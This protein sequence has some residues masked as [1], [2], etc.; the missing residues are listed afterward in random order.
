MFEPLHVESGLRCGCTCPGCGAPLVAR[1][2]P[3]GK[4]VSN[5]A[6]YRGSSCAL[7]FETAVHLAAK[8]LIADRMALYLPAVR[9]HA[10]GV[11]DDGDLFAQP[12]LFVS[13]GVSRLQ[14]VRV[15]ARVGEIRPD[16][17]VSH[18]GRDVLVEIAVTHFVDALKLCHIKGLGLAAVEIDV[19][20][21]REMNFAALEAALFTSEQKSQWLCHPECD[22]EQA[23]LEALVVDEK[24]RRRAEFDRRREEEVARLEAALQHERV[25]L[26]AFRAAPDAAKLRQALEHLGA[27]DADELGFLPVPVKA[28]NAI[29][30]PP[31][32][33]QVAVFSYLLHWAVSVQAVSISSRRVRAWIEERF[34][35]SGNEQAFAGAVWDFL[36]GLAVLGLLHHEGR[37]QFLITFAGSAGARAVVT[38]ARESGALPLSWARSWPE[39]STT[40]C[41]AMV[42]GSAYGSAQKWERVAGLLPKIRGEEPPDAVIQHYAEGGLD[43]GLL[44]RFFLAVGFAR[45][46]GT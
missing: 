18:G 14:A 4:V 19:S 31:L 27:R 6:H 8:Q 33:W 30:A 22:A 3:E 16:L 26:A 36:N 23:R 40:K 37:Q 12:I 11:A 7:G 17:V 32:V 34:P 25:R 13:A 38:D 44:R 2:S 43:A 9:A 42:F 39:R 10:P 28:S 24:A 20:S 35:V 21:V 41:L 15:E 46:A 29:A 1:H 45:L 5:F